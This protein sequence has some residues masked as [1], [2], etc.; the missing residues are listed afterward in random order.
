MRSVAPHQNFV[1]LSF[2]WPRHPVHLWVLFRRRTNLHWT[3]FRGLSSE[4]TQ[5]LLATSTV[6]RTIRIQSRLSSVSSALLPCLKRLATP[7]FC[8]HAAALPSVRKT[9]SQNCYITYLPLFPLPV[10]AHEEFR[11]TLGLCH[12]FLHHALHPHR[13]RALYQHTV[14]RL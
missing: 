12:D 7:S 1:F 6:A 11:G 9:P 2:A 3:Y 10:L 4:C 13:L 8:G 5:F 14:A